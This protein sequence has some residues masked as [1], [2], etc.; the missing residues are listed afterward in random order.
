MNENRS[1]G[2]L[3]TAHHS[4]VV[5]V[6]FDRQSGH[7]AEDPL[8]LLTAVTEPD[9]D[10]LLLHG[11]LLGDERY[12]LRVG[13]WVLEKNRTVLAWCP[14]EVAPALDPK[15]LQFCRKVAFAHPW[16]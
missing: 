12:L 8:L 7:W 10:H 6:R 16:D 4:G 5:A 14:P 11:E 13:F 15:W 2:A 3:E 1:S 9:P